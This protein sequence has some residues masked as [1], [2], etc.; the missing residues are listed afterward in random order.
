MVDCFAYS[1][2]RDL[3][4][5]GADVNF[6]GRRNRTPLFLAA[7]SLDF[8][9]ATFLLDRGA[10]PLVHINSETSSEVGQAIDEGVKWP[11]YRVWNDS[12][13]FGLDVLRYMTHVVLNSLWDKTRDISDAEV[14]KANLLILRLVARGSD[15]F[16]IL[17]ID[18]KVIDQS[19][20]ILDKSSYPP[21]FQWSRSLQHRC[22]FMLNWA[23]VRLLFIGYR[24]GESPLSTL[25]SELVK[26]IS[27]NVML[28]E[29]ADAETA[30]HYHRR[31]SHA[32]RSKFHL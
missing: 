27:H 32:W 15:P 29:R 7:Q 13:G 16:R 5:Q 20:E 11:T 3:V 14:E 24:G 4:L 2:G 25:P 6:R 28:K 30:R 31:A 19:D 23:S 21:F 22:L 17:P 26:I 1:I 8:D 18:K 10:N 12:P 9:L